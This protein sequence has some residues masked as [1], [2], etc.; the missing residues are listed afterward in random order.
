[1]GIMTS[2]DP[3][4]RINTWT[5]NQPKDGFVALPY[6]CC[7]LL[8]QADDPKTD[9]SSNPQRISLLSR[10]EADIAEGIDSSAAPSSASIRAAALGFTM[11]MASSRRSS[12]NRAQSSRDCVERIADFERQGKL[13]KQN[14]E[15]SDSA[16]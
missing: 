7:D 14:E 10:Q 4:E 12:S 3:M 1:M 8:R 9:R 6:K 2:S 11:S 15:M 16:I 13:E 5:R